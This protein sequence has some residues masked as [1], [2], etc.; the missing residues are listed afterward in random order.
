MALNERQNSAFCNVARQRRA[1]ERGSVLHTAP[2]G[3]KQSRTMRN[4]VALRGIAK[5]PSNAKRYGVGEQGIEP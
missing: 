4:I 1:I 3:A 2:R 5:Q